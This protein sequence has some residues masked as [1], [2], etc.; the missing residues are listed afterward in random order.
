MNSAYAYLAIID[1][2][3]GLDAV[4]ER[5]GVLPTRIKKKGAPRVHSASF[6]EN[7]DIWILESPTARS[8]PDVAIH[9]RGLLALLEPRK[10]AV[11]EVADESRGRLTIV[12]YSEHANQEILFTKQ[13]LALLV[14]MGLE[15]WCDFYGVASDEP[16]E[17]PPTP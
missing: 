6:V 7:S 14:E 12:R 16:N 8:E 11:S 13:Q 1:P 3:A 17:T 9:V 2:P 5:I 10:K 4:T 15:V